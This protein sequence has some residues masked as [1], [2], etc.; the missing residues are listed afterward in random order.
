MDY[1]EEHRSSGKSEDYSSEGPDSGSD[2]SETES[3]G[4]SFH[5][6]SGSPFD[7]TQSLISSLTSPNLMPEVLQDVKKKTEWGVPIFPRKSVHLICSSTNSGKTTLLTNILKTREAF[8][9][10]GWL[11]SI[12]YVNCNKINNHTT[13]E[14]PFE[15]LEDDNFPPVHCC[16]LDELAPAEEVFKPGAVVILDDVVAIGETV[17]HMV[18]Y[19]AHHRDLVCFVVVQGCLSSQLFQLLYKVHTLTLSFTNSSS[20]RLALYLLAQFFLSQ[21]KKNQLREIFQRA[22]KHRWVVILKLNTVASSTSL[23]KK[24]VAFSNIHQ[25]FSKKE[26][27]CIVYLEPGEEKIFEQQMALGSDVDDNDFV[28]VKAHQVK[29]IDESAGQSREAASCSNKTRWE[30][31]NAFLLDEIETAFPFNKRSQ[32][33]SLLKEI[34]RVPNF[35][36]SADFRTL[37]IKTKKKLRVSIID[38]IAICIRKAGPGEPPAKFSPYLP[39]VRILL[40]KKIPETY[41]KNSLLVALARGVRRADRPVYGKQNEQFGNSRKRRFDGY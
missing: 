19:A 8:F 1:F 5:S 16:T 20:T 14:N 7:H 13:Y 4:R 34:L 30:E 37:L 36:V 33:I 35:C 21:E 41:L 23:Y 39:F 27:H 31:L 11:K 10:P 38:F 29:K 15:G 6:R 12:V 40:K 22:E 25:L 32:A 24:I 26:P 9:E 2:D 18:T 3:S 28:L 17:N